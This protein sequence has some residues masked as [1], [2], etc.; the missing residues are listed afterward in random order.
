MNKKSVLLVTMFTVM[1]AIAGVNL[2]CDVSTKCN[3]YV[4]NCEKSPYQFSV[5]IEPDNKMVIL[6][7]TNIHADFTNQSEVTFQHIGYTFSINK[8]E[9]SATLT[10]QE[11]VRFGTCKKVEPAW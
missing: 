2:Q 5:F 9:Y 1:P 3:A 8:Y 4:K 11:E 10:N 6:G 7:N